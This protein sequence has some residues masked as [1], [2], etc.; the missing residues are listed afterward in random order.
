LSPVLAAVAISGGI[1]RTIKIL[2]QGLAPQDI[3]LRYDAMNHI[4]AYVWGVSGRQMTNSTVNI[5]QN[6]MIIGGFMSK[7]VSQSSD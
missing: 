5:F 4:A 6:V 3:Y 2:L 1:E 7:T